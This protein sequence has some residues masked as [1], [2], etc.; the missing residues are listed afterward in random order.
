MPAGVDVE[1]GSARSGGFMLSTQPE[2][3]KWF[4]IWVIV[5]VLKGKGKY[6]RTTGHKGPDG[7]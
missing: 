1:F 2:R 6:H 4:P 5:S 3:V 7:E